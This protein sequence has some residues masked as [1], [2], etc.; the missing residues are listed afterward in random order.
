MPSRKAFRAFLHGKVGM[1][2]SFFANGSPFGEAGETKP[3]RHRCAMPPPL[4][5]GGLGIPE[6]L[7]S[8]PEAPLLGELS[9]K[10]TERLYEGQ[11]DRETQKKPPWSCSSL[12]AFRLVSSMEHSRNSIFSI[13][14]FLQKSSA[15]QKVYRTDRQTSPQCARF[16]SF[17]SKSVLYWS[18]GSPRNPLR[19]GVKQ[20]TILLHF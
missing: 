6:S 3:L 19:E 10:V 20:W 8:S 7:A 15:A 12:G 18:C 16:C 11:P 14:D 4:S 2:G 1:R 17:S 13:C 5:R 9:P